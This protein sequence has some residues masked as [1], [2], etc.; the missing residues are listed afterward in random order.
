MAPYSIY[1]MCLVVANNLINSGLT[2]TNTFSIFYCDFVHLFAWSM[3][4][5]MV[6]EGVG[7]FLVFSYVV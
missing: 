4:D 5:Y 1:D 2:T 6:L 3:V 7:Y